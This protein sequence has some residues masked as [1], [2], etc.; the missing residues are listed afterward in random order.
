[1]LTPIGQVNDYLLHPAFHVLRKGDL[2]I[3]VETISEDLKTSTN[4]E[5]D[6]FRY[7]ESSPGFASAD[8]VTYVNSGW[9]SSTS[10]H[11]VHRTERGGDIYLVGAEIQDAR[12]QD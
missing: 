4:I 7:S 1:M 2:D 10:V 12:I 8:F 9:P 6:I 11:T 3:N 5:F